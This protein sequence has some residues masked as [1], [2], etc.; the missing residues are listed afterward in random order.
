M[1]EVVVIKFG[2]GLITNKSQMCTPELDIIDNL[3]G[4]VENCLQQ[5]SD[6]LGH[7][8]LHSE[9]VRQ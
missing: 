9:R 1:A 2:G 8:W 5:G 7:Q 6:A 3:V 4:V